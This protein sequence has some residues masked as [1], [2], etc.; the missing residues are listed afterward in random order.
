V[1][2]AWLGKPQIVVALSS[3]YHEEVRGKDKAPVELYSLVFPAGAVRPL[4]LDRN[5]AL[6]AGLLTPPRFDRRSPALSAG[7]LTPPRF[8]VSHVCSFE[9]SP[10]LTGKQPSGI[11]ASLHLDVPRWLYGPFRPA[12][13]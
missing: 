2:N 8:E 5:T 6:G 3:V 7:L 11:R 10:L 13:E 4:A 1:R 9:S 12:P